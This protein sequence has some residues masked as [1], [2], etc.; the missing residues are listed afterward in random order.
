MIKT[1]IRK[2]K[3]LSDPLKAGL[4]FTICTVIQRAIALLTTPIFTRLL[5]PDQYG[6][7]SVYQAWFSIIQ[8]F[9]TLNLFYGVFNNGMTKYADDRNNFTSAMQGLSTTIT[10]LLF[11]LY[12]CCRK[13]VNSL[14]GLESIYLYA[15]FVELL[16]V[17]AYNFWMAE[18]RYDYKYRTMAI[19]TIAMAFISPCIGVISV[20]LSTYHKAEARVISYIFVQAVVGIYFYIYN[21]RK[22]SHFYNRGYWSFALRFNIPLIPHYLSTTLLNQ[23]DRIMIGNM[24]GIGEAAIY[25]IAYTI[26]TMMNIVTQAI[27]NTFTPYIYKE[28]KEGKIQ[29]IRKNSNSLVVFVFFFM[30][31][32]NAIR[33]R[34]C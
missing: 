27:S 16:F 1:L 18:Q 10:I 6:V 5:S 25:S 15:M 33:A 20:S 32:C 17:P 34:N 26:A 23:V 14:I 4:W 3:Q 13:W 29:N 19:I 21:F 28:L 8:I 12:I 30:F 7:Y 31:T 2:Y 9:A 24:V 11:V 22:S